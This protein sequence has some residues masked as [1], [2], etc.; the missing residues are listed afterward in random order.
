MKSH[1]QQGNDLMTAYFPLQIDHEML[2][3][4]TYTNEAILPSTKDRREVNDQLKANLKSWKASPAHRQLE[5]I[6]SASATKHA[7]TKVIG[8][9]CGSMASDDLPGWGNGPY[10][11]HALIRSVRDWAA[12]KQ[13]QDVACYAQDPVYT[14]VD[15]AVLEE[16]GIQVIDDPRAWLE[17]DDSSVVFSSYPDI[18][19]RE[20]IADLARPAVLICNRVVEDGRED[21]VVRYRVNSIFGI[22]AEWRFNI[23][24][25]PIQTPRGCMP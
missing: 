5:S 12:D 22:C 11:Q 13:S 10:E 21:G 14:G 24:A 6:L 15:K 9:G 18:A 19:V 7:I 2:L 20:M 1:I 3:R 17:V 8:I 23:S 16:S 25:V 4:D